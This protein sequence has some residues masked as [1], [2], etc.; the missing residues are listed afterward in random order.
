M[1]FCLWEKFS[2][3]KKGFDISFSKLFCPKIK[4]V[5][6]RSDIGNKNSKSFVI[7]R[8]IFYCYLLMLVIPSL[9]HEPMK[10]LKIDFQVDR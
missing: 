7:Y 10:R 6:Y 9:F 4:I 3:S 5:L 1:F 2:Q 8:H